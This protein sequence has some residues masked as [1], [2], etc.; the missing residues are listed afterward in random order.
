M[1]RTHRRRL[2]F[3][4]RAL[5]VASITTSIRLWFL[6]TRGVGVDSSI[7]LRPV[8]RRR[9]FVVD[10]IFV[11]VIA[12]V[13]KVASVNTIGRI[14]ASRAIKIGIRTSPSPATR[15]VVGRPSLPTCTTC[16]E[17]YK[18]QPTQRQG[19]PR[20]NQFHRN[21]LR[22][23]SA[24]GPA[25]GKAE[26]PTTRGLRAVSREPSVPNNVGWSSGAWSKTTG[27][28]TTGLDQDR[29]RLLCRSRHCHPPSSPSRLL[30]HFGINSALDNN[31]A[32][33]AH[34]SGVTPDTFGIAALFTSGAPAPRELG[35]E[36]A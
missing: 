31:A 19:F 22:S 35:Q 9:V 16:A 3:G 30:W 20:V 26:L 10:I 28:A 8:A 15:A 32:S 14:R 11:C 18:Q 4:T 12:I 27:R 1:F 21:L 6:M 29:T 7:G 17:C 25:S 36:R 13:R 23:G 33:S 34:G 24:R 2:S 5:V